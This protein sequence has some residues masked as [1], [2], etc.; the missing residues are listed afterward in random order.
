MLGVGNPIVNE[1][2]KQQGK[3]GVRKLS[4]K[5]ARLVPGNKDQAEIMKQAGKVKAL[6]AA[7][8]AEEY[9]MTHTP[10]QAVGSVVGEVIRRPI[11]VGGTI[12]GYVPLRW[13]IYIP[14]TTAMAGASDAAVRKFIPGYGWVTKKLS[15]FYNRALPY[16]K[17]SPKEILQNATNSACYAFQG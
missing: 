13:G 6:K 4:G 8:K 14:G 17:Q 15:S 9:A 12:V 10:G 11:F 7:I 16:L 2:I 3:Q 5:I 1:Q